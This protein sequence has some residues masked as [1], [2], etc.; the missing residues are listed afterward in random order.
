[1]GTC[2]TAGRLFSADGGTL[3]KSRLRKNKLKAPTTDNTQSAS[4]TY[5]R[6]YLSAVVILVR[7][8]GTTVDE[9]VQR[10]YSQKRKKHFFRWHVEGAGEKNYLQCP[11]INA[12]HAIKREA[13]TEK[14]IIYVP[15]S[16]R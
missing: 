9:W 11:G 15:S 16:S 3:C 13:T 4:G 7:I 5:V 2:V 1:M 6:T 10:E 8:I 12:L 14:S